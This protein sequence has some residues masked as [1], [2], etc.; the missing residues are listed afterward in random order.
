M[1]TFNLFIYYNVFYLVLERNCTLYLMKERKKTYATLHLC[2]KNK[3]NTL[4]SAFLSVVLLFICCFGQ[5]KPGSSPVCREK[6]CHYCGNP[7]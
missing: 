3:A 6:P 4:T 5:L 1:K 2:N 7:G